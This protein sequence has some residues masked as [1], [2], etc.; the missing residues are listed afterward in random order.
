MVL[1]SEEP[2]VGAAP[3]GHTRPAWP[4]LDG[5]RGLAVLAVLFFHGGFGWAAGGF[6][7]VSTFFT[8]SGFLITSLLVGEHRRTGSISRRGF[9]G[10][11]LRRLVPAALLG[12]LVVLAFG[13][14]VATPDQQRAL[15]GDMAT[16]LTYTI[17]W[18]FIAS[19]QSYAQLFAAPSPLQHFWSLAVEGQFYLVFGLV[20]AWALHARHPNRRLA[21]L[22]GLAMAASLALTRFAGFSHDRIFYGTDTRAFEILAGSALAL[23]L[24]RRSDP[25]A[26]PSFGRALSL[27]GAV[28]LGACVV[29]WATTS[30]SSSW[31]YA[32][33][34]A[35]YAGLSTLVI[36]AVVLVPAGLFGRLL[37][38]APLRAI[39]LVSYG[40]YVFHWPVFLW[41]TPA[42]THLAL[43]PDF[44]IRM[45]VTT[46]LALASYFLVEVP[47]RRRR[48]P[49][50]TFEPV[51]ARG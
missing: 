4:G 1:T 26:G 51:G 20:A 15:F 42:R 33:G 23:L 17:N 46:A 32:G 7:G 13:F 41:L 24:T 2:S 36:L 48:R 14:T 30:L 19:G 12:A 10:R 11:R 22:V 29:L 9:F 28:A 3:A 50:P 38:V 37:S 47:V 45:L 39:G 31:I 16:A 25:G 5:L 8:L 18:H 27:V 21:I 6:L 49:A 40:L 44:G 43:W 34:L 35:A